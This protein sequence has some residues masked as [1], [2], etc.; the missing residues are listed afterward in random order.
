MIKIAVINLKGGVGKSVTTC[1]LAA[2]LASEQY[3]VLVV[4]VDKQGNTS[5]FFKR[6]D[7]EQPSLAEVLL[8]SAWASD[9]IIDTSLPCVDLLPADMRMLKANRNILMDVT[10]PQQYRLRDA[11]RKVAANYCYCLMD[12][13]PDLDMGSINALCA[14]DWVIIPVDCDEWACDGMAEILDQIARVQMY[15]NPHLKILG[16]LLTKYRNTKYADGVITHLAQMGV[17]LL[18]TAIR[19][20]VRVSEAKSAHLPLRA[21]KQNCTAALDYADLAREIVE[22][23]STADTQE[24]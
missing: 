24:V 7:Y 9:A 3:S 8:G 19:Y 15:Y 21:Y 11:L 2:Q 5:K 12:C 10:E 6:C 18:H 17:P 13:P 20:T 4:D 23:V 16:V 22:K 14:A 1:N